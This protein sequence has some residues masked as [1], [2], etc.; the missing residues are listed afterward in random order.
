MSYSDTVLV[1]ALS[2]GTQSLNYDGGEDFVG[3]PATAASYYSNIGS[4][5]TIMYSL[6][7]FVGSVAVQATLDSNPS[8]SEW[9]DV[10]SIISLTP[11]D[12][13]GVEVIE[14]NFT[15]F[16]TLVSNFTGGTINEIRV[17]Y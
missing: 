7:D 17:I 8:D 16:R 13:S 12:F 9:V 14:G 15:W 4:K 11:G 6:V 1:P 2:H 3:S 5:Q 10:L